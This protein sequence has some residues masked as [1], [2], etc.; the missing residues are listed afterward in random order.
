MFKEID[1]N[2]DGKV[3]FNDFCLMMFQDI[4]DDTVRK[5]TLRPGKWK[6]SIFI[7]GKRQSYHL[8]PVEPDEN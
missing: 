4:D 8:Q 7:K 3:Y 5:L 2:Q 1:E 6:N